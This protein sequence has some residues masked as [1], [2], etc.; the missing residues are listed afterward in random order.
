MPRT[1]RRAGGA[2]RDQRVRSAGAMRGRDD[3]H[4]SQPFLNPAIPAECGA[5]QARKTRSTRRPGGAGTVPTPATLSNPSTRLGEAGEASNG[6]LVRRKRML[7][8]WWY[9]R[10]LGVQFKPTSDS[11][12][13][14]RYQRR[15]YRTGRSSRG[16]SG[17]PSG[18]HGTAGEGP[19]RVYTWR[20]CPIQA[21]PTR[22]GTDPPPPP[23]AIRGRWG[24]IRSGIR[25]NRRC[26]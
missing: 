25:P 5:I 21:H 22:A 19:G 8:R 13:F 18:I 4:L 20:P 9:R 3:P 26:R 12:T 23:L 6:P 2:E 11:P 16:S 14:P 24:A 7:V 1:R 17:G 15:G 10:R